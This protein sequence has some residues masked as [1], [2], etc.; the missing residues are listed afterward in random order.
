M[1]ATWVRLGLHYIMNLDNLILRT[2]TERNTLPTSVLT[3]IIH[4]LLPYIMKGFITAKGSAKFATKP[5]RRL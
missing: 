3:K 4:I 5:L 2:T 1:A